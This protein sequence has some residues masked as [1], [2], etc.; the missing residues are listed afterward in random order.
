MQLDDRWCDER[1]SEYLWSVEVQKNVTSRC[2]PMK[3]AQIVL[4]KEWEG[5]GWGRGD[6]SSPRDTVPCFSQCQWQET[7]ALRQFRAQDKMEMYV[8]S[9]LV[10][11]PPPIYVCVCMCVYVSVA[12]IVGLSVRSPPPRREKRRSGGMIILCSLSSSASGSALI[13]SSSFAPSCRSTW[14]LSSRSGEGLRSFYVFPP[15]LDTRAS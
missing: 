9:S 4:F 12:G 3:Q 6:Q 5:A 15:P 13:D 14:G 2:R 1:A 10:Y 7:K 11:T 8:L